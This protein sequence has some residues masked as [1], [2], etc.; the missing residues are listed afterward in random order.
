[1]KRLFYLICTAVLVACSGGGDGRGGN[2]APPPDP[3][4][5]SVANATVTEVDVGWNELEFTVQLAEPAD[6][7]VTAD[8]AILSGSATNG[9]DFVFPKR[10]VSVAIRKAWINA[11]LPNHQLIRKG[12]SNFRLTYK[13]RLQ[14]AGASNDERDTL[15][16]LRYWR[17]E[18][19]CAV[20]DLERL[21]ELAE[22]T[23]SV[24]E[25]DLPVYYQT[26]G[27]N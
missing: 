21:E 17:R 1:M 11:G 10:D 5:L 25:P 22:K 16:G 23:I 4:E 19:E 14:L 27:P 13:H 3:I 24:K 18:Q 6:Q 26:M 20:V 7:I 9:I 15:L 12:I 2:T 8:Y